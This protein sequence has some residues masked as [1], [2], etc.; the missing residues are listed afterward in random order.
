MAYSRWLKLSVFAVILSAISVFAHSTIVSAATDVN[1]SAS[2]SRLN[3]ATLLLG[4]VYFYD[5]DTT[6]STWEFV[7]VNT[8]C[9]AKIVYKGASGGKGGGTSA[10][11]TLSYSNPKQAA[12]GCGATNTKSLGTPKDW[13]ARENVVFAGSPAEKKVISVLPTNGTT[14]KIASKTYNGW[15]VFIEEGKNAYSCPLVIANSGSNWRYI[16]LELKSKEGDVSN[17]IK[18]LFASELGVNDTACGPTDNDS[19]GLFSSFGLPESYYDA[20][21]KK[22]HYAKTDFGL[23]GDDVGSATLSVYSIASAGGIALAGPLKGGDYDP[24]QDAGTL[25]GSNG[26]FTTTCAIDGIGWIVCPV[27]DFMANVI[28]KMYNVVSALLGVQPLTANTSKSS[29]YSAWSIMRNLANVAFVVAFL[30]LV[31]SQLTGGGISNYGIKKMLPRLI[32][33]AVL[34]NVS[35]WICAI[36]VDISNIA[37]NSLKAMFDSL[38]ARIETPD[39]GASST[40]EGWAGMVGLILAGGIAGV[41]VYLGVGALLVAL[42]SALLAIITVF[43]VLTLRQALIII[44]IV[45]SPLAFVA[46]LLPN[47]SEWFK[48]WMTTFQ[49][50]LLMYPIIALIFGGSAFAAQIITTSATG[51]DGDG[52]LFIQLMGAL[53]AILPLAITPIVLKFSGGILN[54]FAGIVNNPNRGPFDAMRKRAEATRDRI[55][56]N[57]DRRALDPS[58]RWQRITGANRRSRLRGEMQRDATKQRRDAAYENF[59]NTDRRTSRITGRETGAA[60]AKENALMAQETAHKSGEVLQ[61]QAKLRH[62]NENE[63]LHT[64]AID[65]GKTLQNAEAT[66]RAEAETAHVRANPNQYDTLREAQGEQKNAEMAAERRFEGSQIGRAQAGERQ[67]LEGDLKIIRGEQELAFKTSA[68]G[69]VQAQAERAIQ[70]EVKIADTQADI[71]YG[72]S[73]VGESQA[74]REAVASDQ[75]SAVNADTEAIVQELRTE[76]G[77]KANP[78]YTAEAQELRQADI[79]KRVQQQRSGAAQRVASYDYASQIRDD[80]TGLAD[81]AAGIEGETGK[82]QAQA[83]A[84]QTMIETFNKGVAAESTLMSNTPE[85]EILAER[86]SDGNIMLGSDDILDQPDEK[87]TAMGSVI[88]KR[89]HMESHIKLWERMGDLYKQETAKRDAAKASGDKVA[90]KKAEDNIGKIR[91]LQQQVMQ[92]KSKKPFGIGDKD[93]GDATVGNYSNDIYESTRERILTHLNDG[94]LSSMDPDD[95]RLLFEMG[96]DGKL[97]P[98]HIKKI[99]DSY[100]AWENNPNLKH[101]IKDKTRDLLEPIVYNA[102]PTSD[103]AS[104]FDLS[105]LSNA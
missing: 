75:L 92:D 63:E 37:G 39:F 73:K 71:Q 7:G 28:D 49:T 38:G 60:V 8:N 69:E 74:I 78:Q 10:S 52:K 89:Q 29:L 2:V 1:P 100:E 72:A 59:N 70:K 104:R 50:L 40:G 65:T 103:T 57:R 34:V 12:D 94:A 19:L 16:P 81:R 95:M 25:S 11:W 3:R 80:S 85:T 14:F 68:P 56:N 53:V 67:G 61:N 4:S 83:V 17:Q 5:S 41:S 84:R 86:D 88:A 51:A 20:G 93:Q 13:T 44:L 18:A 26:E 90:Q 76:E 99:Q 45:I 64:Q 36:A 77:A 32:V 79:E 43:L 96:R 21:V 58:N 47:T 23:S 30:I 35:F 42:P 24:K 27:M 105:G 55:N 6:D 102:Y 66:H 91:N 62:L 48:R 33:A 15:T 87:I 9:P 101:L 31:Y 54:R 97:S 82:S 98:Q 22:L 46:Y